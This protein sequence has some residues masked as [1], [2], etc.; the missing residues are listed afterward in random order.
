MFC[1]APDCGKP[2]ISLDLCIEHFQPPGPNV[3]TQNDPQHHSRATAGGLFAPPNIKQEQL[4]QM[5]DLIDG[6]ARREAALKRMNEMFP[7]NR[8]LKPI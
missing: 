1:S 2:A 7:V 3:P 4:K 5:P 6:E 8:G